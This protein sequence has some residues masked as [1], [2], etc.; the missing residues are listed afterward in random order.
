VQRYDL[1]DSGFQGTLVNL[2]REKVAGSGLL[3]KAPTADP[4]YTV[5][6]DD[7]F[8]EGS[9]GYMLRQDD[10]T[11]EGV[12]TFQFEC[13]NDRAQ[14]VIYTTAV[15]TYRWHVQPGGRD[16]DLLYATPLGDAF[17]LPAGAMY[18]IPD[19]SASNGW[20][21]YAANEEMTK[22]IH[23]LRL[24]II[25]DDGVTNAEVTDVDVVMDYPDV[26]YTVNDH[27]LPAGG[28]RITFPSGTF[29]SLKA[30][31]VT[32]QDDGT[33]PG[34]ASNA[35]I[36]LKAPGYVDL[37]PVDSAGAPAAGVADIVAIGW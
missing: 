16:T 36:R 37:A 30:V 14:L 32:M 21:P 4:I 35:V 6:L 2:H 18:P 22:G 26:V 28:G 8:Y 17:Y 7:E 29:R 10:P 12:Y 33:H 1:R 34:V 23:Q 15:G 5:P 9:S 13:L 31:S 11:T 25:S 3:Y 20:H 19:S 27:A 24:T